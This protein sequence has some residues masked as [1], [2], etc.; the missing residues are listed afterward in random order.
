M[1]LPGRW[2]SG[3]TAVGSTVLAQVLDFRRYIETAEA[4]QIAEEERKAI[5]NR[6]LPY[7]QVFGL[8]EVWSKKFALLGAAEP[9]DWYVG[10]STPDYSGV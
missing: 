3:R 7:A 6:Y 8:A 5:F 10:S 4:T 2:L 9:G 1:F